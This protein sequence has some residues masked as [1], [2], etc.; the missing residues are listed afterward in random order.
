MGNY[1]SLYQ[2]YKKGYEDLWN[3]V[4]INVDNVS[5]IND[6]VDAIAANI[7]KYNQVAIATG[8]PWYMIAI[9][10]S[11]EASLSFRCHL[12]NGDS[13]SRRTVNEPSGRPRYGEPPFDW[14]T[15]AIDAIQQILSEEGKWSD[16]PLEWSIPAIL[17]RLELY[18]G[19]GYRGRINSPYLWSMTNHYTSGKFVSDGSYDPDAVSEQCGAAAIIAM[20]IEREIICKREITIYV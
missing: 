3:T 9:I 2:K 15:S 19:T 7:D 10:H 12:H 20:L 11:L 8:M 13:L 14:K 6:I 16:P 1:A 4:K 18:N 17:F 5:E